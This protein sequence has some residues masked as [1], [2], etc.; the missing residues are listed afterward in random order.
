M[1]IVF[2]ILT[3]LTFST[4]FAVDNPVSSV[5]TAAKSFY[6][7][8]C[9]DQQGNSFRLEVYRLAAIVEFSGADLYEGGSLKLVSMDIGFNSEKTVYQMSNGGELI[10]SERAFVGRGGGRGGF[11]G[12]FKRLV[13]ARLTTNEKIYYFNCN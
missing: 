9:A 5:D 8:I 7:Q 1:K 10:I 2:S 6:G 3:F 11:D 13:A 4:A 12:T